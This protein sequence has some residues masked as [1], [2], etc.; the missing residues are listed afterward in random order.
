MPGIQGAAEI[1]K[2]EAQD[3]ELRIETTSA[4]AFF[5]EIDKDV[6]LQVVLNLIDNAYKYSGEEKLIKVNVRGEADGVR[7]EVVDR[8]IGIPRDKIEKIFERFYRA[9]R[10]DV[11][12]I[13]GSGVGLSLVKSIVDAHDGK[14]AV[15]S[16]MGKG[17]KFI[18]LLPKNKL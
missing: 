15:E 16:E 8:G 17:S 4:G 5:A 2:D 18:I 9:D 10:E 12:N 11:R 14:I 1:Y 7:L 13:K 3:E 6:M